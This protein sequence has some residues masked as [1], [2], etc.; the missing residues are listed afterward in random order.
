MLSN[1]FLVF[2]LYD[3][4]NFDDIFS[5]CNVSKILRK[6]YIDRL[7][8]NSRNLLQNTLLAN[9][10]NL[11][12]SEYILYNKYTKIKNACAK[13]YSEKNLKTYGR[14]K[15]QF[16]L[17]KVCRNYLIVA[18]H[19]IKY[20]FGDGYIKLGNMAHLQRIIPKIYAN[21]YKYKEQNKIEKYIFLPSILKELKNMVESIWDNDK[22]LV[23]KIDLIQKYSFII[24]QI[25]GMKY[26]KKRINKKYTQKGFYINGL[27]IPDNET[28]KRWIGTV[29]RGIRKSDSRFIF[30]IGNSYVLKYN[31]PIA[32]YSY[33]PTDLIWENDRN[34]SEEFKLFVHNILCLD[35]L[36]RSKFG[37]VINISHLIDLKAFHWKLDIN[38]INNL[39]MIPN[40][41]FENT[42]LN[43]II[44]I[45]PTE[46]VEPSRK[47]RRT[48]L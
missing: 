35:E 28:F 48:F 14:E 5:I 38:T 11:T 16:K 17:C 30:H 19:E 26:M 37:K 2:V 3:F 47:K 40:D 18:T 31:I 7:K 15:I 46:T 8:Y 41:D 23:Y 10:Y 20:L 1:N 12:L 36:S 22:I 42:K 34:H 45:N 29:R 32:S 27:I 6:C 24:K 44:T 33:D 39:L 25:L 4:L 21:T 43:M 9:N 13:C